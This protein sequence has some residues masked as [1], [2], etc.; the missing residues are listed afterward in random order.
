MAHEQPRSWPALLL[1]AVLPLLLLWPNLT[2]SRRFV[3]YDLG[4][5]PPAS[6]K[7]EPADLERMRTDANL[8]VTEVPVWFVPEL[9]FAQE[10][11]A[12]GE[13][14]TWNP[15]ARGG[16]PVHAHGLLGLAYPPNW[17]LFLADD[18]ERGL[19]WTCWVSLVVA[20]WLTFG[21]LRH[22]GMGVLAACFG[23]LVFQCSQTLA[24]NAPFWMRLASLVW[25]PGVLWSMLAVAD[26]PRRAGPVA[27]LGACSAMPWL[28]GFPPF[29]AAGSLLAAGF[30]IALCTHRWHAM[31]PR[32]AG[33][34]LATLAAG[35]V[36]GA[37]VA[38]VQLLPTLAFFPHSARA[39]APDVDTV[40]QSAFDPVNFVGW[41]VPNLFGTPWT[42]SVLPYDRSP[43]LLQWCGLEGADGRAL[44]PNHNHT[45]YA[46]YPGVLAFL[47]AVHGALYGAGRFRRFA[48]LALVAASALGTCAGPLEQLFRLPLLQNVWPM[49][50]PAAAML[51]VAWLAASGLDRM[52]GDGKGA[53][54]LLVGGTVL[55][56]LTQWQA[57]RFALG[58][59]ELV[60]AVSIDIAARYREMRSGI[61]LAFVRDEYVGLATFRAAFEQAAGAL[62]R[63]T[64]FSLV[65]A[66]TGLLVLIFRFS[67]RIRAG[68]MLLVL[69]VAAV[70]LLP[71]SSRYLRGQQ[72]GT[73]SSTAVHGF[74]AGQ[75]TRAAG[76]GG[77]TVARASRTP[78]LPSQ[79]PPG[80]LLPLGI[81][82][83]QFDT[84]YDGR[85]HEPLV[86]LF[87]PETA[88]KGY[89]ARTLPDDARLQHPLLDLLGIRY[90]LATEELA[91]GGTRVGPPF[92]GPGGSFHVHERASA[93]P[94]AFTV[95][96]LRVLP[97]DE[98]VLAHM[99]STG[100]RPADEA[101]CTAAGAPATDPAAGAAPPRAVRFV[102]DRATDVTLEVGAGSACWLVLTDTML[103]GWSATVD[104]HEV[105]V[106]RVNH[107]MRGVEL[108]EGACTVRFRYAA[109]GLAA[110]M[111]A[112]GVGLAVLAALGLVT[113]LRA[114]QRTAPV[115]G[116]S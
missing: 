26:S 76:D 99:T 20:G 24:A 34:L 15:T 33:S 45:E 98:A 21:L 49:R 1:L 79:L 70:D 53:T 75:R 41:L 86:R 105:A 43:L 48:A 37:L 110:G 44:L 95:G 19:G 11:L 54:W 29:A 88:A 25:L 17:L 97:D 81:R 80:M 94:R 82:D 27:A 85:S 72:A 39:T 91:A 40:L 30:G 13:L 14:P 109:P 57:E 87:G 59:S 28:A 46:L 65:A 7:A 83:L 63:T 69:L 101:L 89:V 52:R 108:P 103:P 64:L 78:T 113:L 58:T 35:A 114:R 56:A 51:L 74:L 47:L 9:R 31:G 32:A 38:S 2:G 3:P 73:D 8:D 50:L 84:H 60:D 106:L 62:T 66:G 4:L 90:V 115:A 36:L 16:A 55:A 10:Q 93:L 107:S 23:A 102:D 6:L 18:P 111:V 116:P 112:S 92:A 12:A 71:V 96:T 100:F 22:L 104:G 61:D 68:A 67:R 42:T 77:F 5:F